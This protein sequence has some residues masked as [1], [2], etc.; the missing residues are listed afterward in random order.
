MTVLEFKADRECEKC[1]SPDVDVL[2]DERHDH[3]RKTCRACGHHW[4][5]YPKDHVH[6]EHEAEPRRRPMPLPL[7]WVFRH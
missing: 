5:E 3:L 2:Y 4:L 1:G 6:R 7:Q